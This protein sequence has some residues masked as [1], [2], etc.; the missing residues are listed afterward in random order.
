MGRGTVGLDMAV[1]H[2]QQRA[3]PLAFMV[4]C[5]LSAHGSLL[6]VVSLRT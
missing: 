4:S 5:V 1:T 6:F 2:F 3:L